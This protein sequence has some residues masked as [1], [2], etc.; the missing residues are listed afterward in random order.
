[1]VIIYTNEIFSAL[2]RTIY[3]VVNRSPQQLLKEI[4]LVD[5]FS[6]KPELKAPLDQYVDD[7]FDG[8]VK[9]IRLD[10]VTQRN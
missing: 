5:D 2:V 10:K 9:I 8:L 6:D 3:S 7:Y 4:I 1:M